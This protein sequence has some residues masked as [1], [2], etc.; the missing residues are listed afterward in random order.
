MTQPRCLNLREPAGGSRG[1]AP[2]P[3]TILS[4]ALLHDGRVEAHGLL[5]KAVLVNEGPDAHVDQYS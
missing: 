4:S 2:R 1:L 3:S 5:A